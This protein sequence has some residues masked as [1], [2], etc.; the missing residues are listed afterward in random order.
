[1]LSAAPDGVRLKIRLTPRG[2]ADRIDG[3]AAKALKCL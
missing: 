1:V 2:R 3:V